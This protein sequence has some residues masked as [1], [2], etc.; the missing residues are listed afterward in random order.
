MRSSAPALALALLLAACAAP[1]EPAPILE[2]STTEAGRLGFDPPT[3]VA[4][5]AVTTPAAGAREP[6]VVVTEFFDLT[7]KYC[8]YAARIVERVERHWPDVVQVQYRHFALSAEGELL[9]VAAQAAHRQGRF[10]CFIGALYATRDTWIDQGAVGREGAIAAAV[11]RCGLDAYR[12]EKDRGDSRLVD[13]VREDKALGL[14]LGVDGTPAYLVDGQPVVPVP[15][16]GVPPDQTL[17]A[18][19]RRHLTAARQAVAHGRAW[20]S[21]IVLAADATLQDPEAALWLVEGTLPYAAE[22][23]PDDTVYPF[24]GA[25]DDGE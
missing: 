2:S 4:A 13:K 22:P 16:F 12:F 19:V 10:R 3:E 15:F 17:M 6:L 24:R 1:A 7:C 25:Y 5:D 8:A 23:E 20:D 11:H 21:V 18:T 9:G 14:R